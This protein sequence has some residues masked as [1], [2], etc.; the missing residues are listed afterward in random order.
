MKKNVETVIKNI[1]CQNT[2]LLAMQSAEIYYNA[3]ITAGATPQEAR[4][5]LPN[6][7]KSNIIITG[8]FKQFDHYFTLRDFVLAHPQMSLVAKQMH[9]MVKA[10]RAEL[11]I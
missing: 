6:S 1:R 3:M 2:W 8:S 7:V 4:S 11:G 9:E 5:V 10:R